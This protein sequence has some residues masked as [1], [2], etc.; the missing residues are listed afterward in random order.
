MSLFWALSAQM[1]QHV[2]VLFHQNDADLQILCFACSAQQTAACTVKFSQ[3]MGLLGLFQQEEPPDVQ[4]IHP[5]HLSAQGLVVPV[6]ADCLSK[7][8][9]CK[10]LDP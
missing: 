8:I 6:L 9:R 4:L 7:S 1:E 10:R 3:G 2:G 5:W